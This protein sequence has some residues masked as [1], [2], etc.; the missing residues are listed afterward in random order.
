MVAMGPAATAEAA[1]RIRTAIR[2]ANARLAGG[3]AARGA[4]AA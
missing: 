3:G 1:A 2:I 4:G